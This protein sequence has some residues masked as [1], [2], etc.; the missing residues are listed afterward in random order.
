MPSKKNGVGGDRFFWS[1]RV[2]NAGSIEKE[3]R[4]LQW[5]A[6]VPSEKMAQGGDRFFVV[7]PCL[8]YRVDRK[9]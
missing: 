7:A 8:Q 2:F 9:R 4:P 5:N 6:S 1:L 3:D